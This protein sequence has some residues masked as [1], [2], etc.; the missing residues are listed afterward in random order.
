MN[1]SPYIFPGLESTDK[2]EHILRMCCNAAG[3]EREQ[4]VSESRLREV[5]LA[6]QLYFWFARKLTTYRLKEIGA[7]VNLSHPSVVHHLNVAKDY[8]RI[9]DPDFLK[10]YNRIA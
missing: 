5:V 6:R 3:V 8:L 10:L 7:L 4:A 1:V 2:L 9:K